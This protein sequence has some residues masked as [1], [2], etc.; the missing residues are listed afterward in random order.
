MAK[1]MQQIIEKAREELSRFTGLE[2]STT[3]GAAKDEKGWKVTM[4]MIE[5][6]SIPDQM[7]ILATYEVILDDDGNVMEFNR[8]RLRK[9]ADTET[10]EVE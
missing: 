5:K 10:V 3:L 2:L 6:H 4:E 8:T 1:T 7:D 9:R